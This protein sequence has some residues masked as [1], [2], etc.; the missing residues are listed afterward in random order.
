MLLKDNHISSPRWS[1]ARKI[2][3]LIN[4][5]PN[6]K[7]FKQL[8]KQHHKGFTSKSC[9]L[10]YIHAAL[11]RHHKL[12]GIQTLYNCRSAYLQSAYKIKP[13]NNKLQQMYDSALN[14]L[15]KRRNSSIYENPKRYK[16]SSSEYCNENLQK[17]TPFSAPN[18]FIKCDEFKKKIISISQRNVRFGQTPSFIKLDKEKSNETGQEIMNKHLLLHTNLGK[19]STIIITVHII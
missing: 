11:Q 13:S 10:V 8:S 16:A 1:I 19:K 9:N 4:V 3:I 14:L 7:S 12:D 18:E 15:L 17:E 6:F 5:K 2:P